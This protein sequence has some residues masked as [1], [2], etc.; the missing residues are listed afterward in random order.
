M[1]AQPQPAAL[2]AVPELEGLPRLVSMQVIA[3]E[4]A[5]ASL[6]RSGARAVPLLKPSH[7]IPG[8]WAFPP[9]AQMHTGPDVE[10]GSA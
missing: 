8:D 1:G 9:S 3:G 4:S 7:A 5:G 10:A 6:G 2:Q